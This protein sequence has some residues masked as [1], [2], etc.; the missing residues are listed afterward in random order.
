MLAKNL[1]IKD[2]YRVCLVTDHKR[3][4]GIHVYYVVEYMRLVLWCIPMWVKIK[5]GFKH[6]KVERATE[7]MVEYVTKAQELYDNEIIKTKK[8]CYVR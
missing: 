5:R 1:K 2:R 7:D 6:I 3:G 4:G 8:V